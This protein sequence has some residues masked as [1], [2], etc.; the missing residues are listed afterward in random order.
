MSSSGVVDLT[1]LPLLLT[2]PEL[3]QIY[4]ISASTI[5]KALQNGTFTPQPWAT[6]PYR[7]RREDVL[8]DLRRP[9]DEKPHKPHGFAST[10][11]RRQK[12]AALEPQRT[13][14]AS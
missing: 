4:R 11:T 7:W 12:K 8:A 3:A 9:R 10:K 2:I 14:T 6:Y 13:R 1:A 5:R